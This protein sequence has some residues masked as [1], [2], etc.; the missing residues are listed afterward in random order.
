MGW[1]ESG[2]SQSWA[3]V[4]FPKAAVQSH[5]PCAVQM[6]RSSFPTTL[7]KKCPTLCNSFTPL[8]VTKANP[9]SPHLL[10]RGGEQKGDFNGAGV[11]RLLV[12][13]S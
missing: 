4:C 3:F 8:S 11:A 13:S 2:V 1:K 9:E 6:S 12:A 10:L 7:C 5:L